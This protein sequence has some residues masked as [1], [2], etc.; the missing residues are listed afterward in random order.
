MIPLIGNVVLLKLLVAF[1][2]S[3]D[4]HAPAYLTPEMEGSKPFPRSSLSQ[5]LLRLRDGPGRIHEADVTEGLREVAQQFASRRV[6]LLGE[7]PDVIHIGHRPLEGRPR[8]LDLASQRQ[9]T[10][11]PERAE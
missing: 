7:Q 6:Y 11:K 8:P 5:P 3:L 2:D 10:G 1:L 4:I 9:R